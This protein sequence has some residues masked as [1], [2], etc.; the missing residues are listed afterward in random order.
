[1]RKNEECVV[2][3]HSFDPSVDV[4]VDENNTDTLLSDLYH[5]Y[6]QEE[7]D[8]HSDLDENRCLIYDDEG[9]AQITWA[10]GGQTFFTRTN[11][12]RLPKTKP[13]LSNPVRQMLSSTSINAANISNIIKT[14]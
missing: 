9:W 7:I 5:T 2:V 8:N 1:M 11:V 13:S 10:D 6:L 3:Y 4:Y 12:T 14:P